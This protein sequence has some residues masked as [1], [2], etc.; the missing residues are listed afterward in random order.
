[1]S[2][3]Q[4]YILYDKNII[5]GLFILSIPVIFSNILKS[6]HDLVDMYFVAKINLPIEVVDAQ[7]ASITVTASIMGLFQALAIGLM[8]AGG[9]LMSQYLGAKKYNE[10][11]RVSG[12]LFVSCTIVGIFCNILLYFGAPF[13]MKLM[14]A[15]GLIYDYSVIYLQYRSFELTGLFIFYSYQA[16][17]QST[18]DTLTPVILNSSSIILNIILTAVLINVFGMDIRG[19]ALGTVIGNMIIVIPSVLLLVKSNNIEINISLED[20]KFDKDVLKKI[21]ILGAP[22]AF[23]Q[24]LTSLGFA[25]VNS[26]SMR[27][28]DYIIT[29]IGAG[30]RINSLLLYPTMSIGG[31]VSTFVGQNIGAENIKRAKDSMKAG[32]ILSLLIAVIGLFCLIPF[33]QNIIGALLNEESSALGI[34]SEYLMYLILN[35][36][37]LSIFQ[38]MNNTFQGAG[39]TDYSLFT[40]SLRLWVLRIPFIILYLDILKTNYLG[41]AYAMIISNIGIC[42]VCFLLYYKVDFKPRTNKMSKKIQALG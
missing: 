38:I 39:R 34:G 9:A 1:M 21:I 30:N 22:A 24:A 32:L 29:G 10:A 31:V 36:P 3:K 35:L 11:R 19:A 17:R 14:N 12:Q 18:G 5:K 20:I 15:E 27:F 4:R 7:T 16:T 41:L 6:V 25:L 28:D 37:C 13:I 26:F 2:N 40:S 42:L 23:S 8:V 33:R